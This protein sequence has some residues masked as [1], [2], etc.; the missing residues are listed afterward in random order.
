MVESATSRLVALLTET[1]Y[2]ELPV[3]VYRKRLKASL[4]H[5][6]QSCELCCPDGKSVEVALTTSRRYDPNLIH[7]CLTSVRWKDL[8]S[9][10][11]A[12]IRKQNDGPLTLFLQSLIDPTLWPS[13][14][15]STVLECL[16]EAW[17]FQLQASSPSSAF[18]TSSQHSKESRPSHPYLLELMTDRLLKRHPSLLVTAV[19]QILHAAT[20][21]VHTVEQ[22]LSLLCLL[23]HWFGVFPSRRAFWLDKLLELLVRL[24]ELEAALVQQQSAA[25]AVNNKRY[26]TPSRTFDTDNTS[27]SNTRQRSTGFNLQYLHGELSEEE[28]GELARKVAR[29]QGRPQS[30][31][32]LLG[33]SDLLRADTSSDSTAVNGEILLKLWKFRAK[34]IKMLLSMSHTTAHSWSKSGSLPRCANPFTTL[35]QM[36]L[37]VAGK[38][39]TNS[40]A[41]RLAAI[42]LTRAQGAVDQKAKHGN[43]HSETRLQPLMDLVWQRAA[44][45]PDSYALAVFYFRFYSELLSESSEFDNLDR[46]QQAVTPFLQLI[47]TM[48]ACD[49]ICHPLLLDSTEENLKGCE[50]RAKVKAYLW[51]FSFLL[52]RRGSMLLIS[53][54]NTTVDDDNFHHRFTR[55]LEQLSLSFASTSDWIDPMLPLGER[56][57]QVQALQ[58]VGLLGMSASC[59]AERLA[60]VAAPFTNIRIMAQR[61]EAWTQIPFFESEGSHEKKP[62]PIFSPYSPTNEVPPSVLA[63]QQSKPSASRSQQQQRPNL[64]TMEKLDDNLLQ[65]VFSFLNYKWVARMRSVCTCWKE[66]ADANS[67]WQSLY[68]DKY[69][70]LPDDPIW[71]STDS[72]SLNWKQLFTDR[73]LAGTE[74]RF[75]YARTDPT[76]KVRICSYIGCLHVLSTPK[77]QKQ[78]YKAHQ[79][80]KRQA[81]KKAPTGRKRGRP[82][83]G[84]DAGNGDKK[85]KRMKS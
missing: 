49:T 13:C 47:K 75:R 84:K 57:R 46:L 51:S 18:G 30:Q 23:K 48:T 21:K 66:N 67:L 56:E 5:V 31:Q 17:I 73:Y 41:I 22:A 77:Q 8:C 10:Y 59:E 58:A 39:P 12:T 44:S 69:G 14:C 83:K 68:D 15:V 70:S 43:D 35:L 45:D 1:A 9:S 32:P 71:Q 76:W 42:E 74:I 82:R 24:E 25:S 52:S 64:P 28:E 40:T 4:E 34:C 72:Q 63:R 3:S 29:K 2:G 62:S 7:E 53:R 20:E 80:N 6:L 37:G 27:N 38:H 54:K 16:V 50:E 60:S 79:N 61:I 85:M 78:H 33:L 19:G 26:S 36:V 55:L 81:N 65:R 11:D